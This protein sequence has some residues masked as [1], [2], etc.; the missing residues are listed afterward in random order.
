VANPSVGFE[1]TF[2]GLQ[3]FGNANYAWRSSFF[4]SSDSSRLA[5]L[6]AF[7]VVNVR[8]GVRGT[9]QGRPWSLALW[10][11]NALDETYF[12][13][14]ARGANGE[15]SGLRGLARTYGATVRLDF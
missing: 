7:G 9:A 8:L 11:N 14:L 10:S 15:Y 13:S 3:V 2:A 6:D 12:Q 5:E 1:H 4:G